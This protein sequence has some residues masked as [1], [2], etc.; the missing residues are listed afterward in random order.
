MAIKWRCYPV[1]IH[2]VGRDYKPYYLSG[3]VLSNCNLSYFFDIVQW[4]FAVLTS[5][6]VDRNIAGIFLKYFHSDFVIGGKNRSV[7]IWV[8]DIVIFY[9]TSIV[10]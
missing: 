6:L 9:V 3:S 10:K 2:T 1:Q 7:L 4:W 5:R 8:V